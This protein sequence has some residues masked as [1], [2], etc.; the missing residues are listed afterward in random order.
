MVLRLPFSVRLQLAM[1]V[2]KERGKPEKNLSTQKY[3]NE[4]LDLKKFA[5]GKY[6][7]AKKTE[8]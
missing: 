2:F 1:L 6:V 3:W 8:E 4:K 7:V 5:S